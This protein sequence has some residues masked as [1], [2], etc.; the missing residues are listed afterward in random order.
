MLCHPSS[1]ISLNP[2]LKRLQNA[3]SSRKRTADTSVPDWQEDSSESMSSRQDLKS[4]PGISIRPSDSSCRLQTTASGRMTIT[5][6][7]TTPTW[8]HTPISAENS[9][10]SSSGTA[11]KPSRW[12]ACMGLSMFSRRRSP[13]GLWS[14]IGSRPRRNETS[15]VI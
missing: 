12:H 4:L 3:A 15:Q 10:M 5:G 13:N 14:T 11:G 6:C 8:G 1:L 9:A 2:S 7:T